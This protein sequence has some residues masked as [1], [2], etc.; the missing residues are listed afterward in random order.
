MG[1]GFDRIF[2]L[3]CNE[4][5]AVV[6]ASHRILPAVLHAAKGHF[7]CRDGLQNTL[8][9]DVGDRSLFFFGLLESYTF[10]SILNIFSSNLW[11]VYG[12]PGPLY[13]EWGRG[14]R[15]R[16]TFPHPI[17]LGDA[18]AMSIPVTMYLI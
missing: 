11:I 2:H 4:R 12:G 3:G 15:I 18:I 5:E 8:C 7:E 6:R 14:L 17:L 10:W 9:N 13:V 16:S 1:G